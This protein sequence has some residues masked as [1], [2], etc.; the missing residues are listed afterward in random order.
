MREKEAG[1]LTLSDFKILKSYSNPNNMV[2]IKIQTYKLMEQDRQLRNKSLHI[3]IIF[4]NGAN[5][6]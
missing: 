6:I 5:T 3:Q 4:N 2:P 1:G